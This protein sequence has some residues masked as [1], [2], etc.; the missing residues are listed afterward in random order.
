MANKIFVA[1]VIALWLSSMSWLVAVRI[2][3]S[4]G[5]GDRPLAEGYEI[6]KAVAWRID[7]AGAD[8][9]RAASVRI[10]GVGGTVD[11]HNRLR[12]E[13]FPLM[14]LTPSWM[15]FAMGEIGDMTF[16]AATRIEFDS[17]GNFSS[18]HSRIKLNDLPSALKLSGRIK[19]SYLELKVS[20]GSL[21]HFA[22]VYLPDSKA[23][24]ESL[25]PAARLPNLKIGRH[26]KEE[27]Y[28][29]FRTPDHPTELV[30]VEVIGVE[31]MEYGGILS[32]VLRVEYRAISGT[33]V[34]EKSRLL[35]VS[36]VDPEDGDVLRRD[37]VIGNTKLRFERLPDAEAE[38]VGEK[39]FEEIL[40]FERSTSMPA[41]GGSSEEVEE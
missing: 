32:R 6:G 29:P 7:W 10:A 14:Y 30:Q 17:L 2:L 8:V 5:D 27:V 21:T 22:P 41:Q 11:L 35:A 16:D 20:A 39:L 37:M 19:D 1:S 28:S 24:S 36:W 3:P 15:R 40:H 31:P 34:P 26:W 9:G 4:F 38:E 13:K 33:G 18:F 23:L 12:L 25:F